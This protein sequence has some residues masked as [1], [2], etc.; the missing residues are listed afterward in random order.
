[1][2]PLRCIL[3]CL[4]LA[5]GFSTRA[6]DL[7]LP[8]GWFAKTFPASNP[9]PNDDL[10]CANYSLDEWYLKI[11]SGKLRISLSLEE[12]RPA[13]PPRF[14]LTE[15]MKGKPVVARASNGW[16]VGFDAGELGG[17]LWWTS[18]NGREKKKLSNENIH[19]IAPRGKELLVL[20]GLAHGATDEGKVYSYQSAT[21]QAGNLDQIADLSS[22]PGA[23]LVEKDGSVLIATQT[24]IVA[25]DGSNQLRVL[26]QN[27]DMSLLYPHS[28]AEDAA[29]N[30]FVGM[31]YFILRLRRNAGGEYTPQW[32]A[33]NR[34]VKTVIR[35][36]RCVCA[37]NE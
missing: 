25:L 27:N 5:F 3:P 6:Q 30:I 36:S 15:E 22:A 35:D 34:C 17:G 11:E 24:R 7:Q 37:A 26:F 23:A 28:I 4:V 31:R 10:L 8:S 33:H 21:Q 12:E 20:A 32:Y 16:L 14:T 9:Q 29:G 18:E 13:F 2:K 1:M 19:A